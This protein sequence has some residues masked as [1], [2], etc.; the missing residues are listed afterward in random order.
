MVMVV[1]LAAA[2][3]VAMRG[4]SGSGGQRDVSC[5]PQRAESQEAGVAATASGTFGTTAKSGW[6]MGYRASRNANR[7][8][9]NPCGL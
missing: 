6:D 8:D 9:D 2:R 7:P 3:A 4:G 5:P 1:I